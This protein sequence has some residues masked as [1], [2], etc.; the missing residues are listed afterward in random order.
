[1]LLNQLIRINEA[2]T[3]ADSVNFGLMEQRETNQKLC[4]GFVFNYDREKLTESTIGV[5][6][7]LRSSYDS[8]SHANVHLLV[9]QYGKGK[10]HFAVT[11][12][13]YFSK[14]AN[15]PEVEGILQQVENATG[16][17]TNAL[18]E[19]LRLYKNQGRHLVLCLSGDRSGDIKK[20]FLQSLLRV[21]E[22]EGITDS[23]AQHICSE[24]LNYLQGLDSDQRERAETYLEEEGSSDGDVNSITQ[25]L[26]K[27]N[28]AV[29]PTLKKLARHLTGFVPDW[30]IGVDIENVLENLI[31]THCSGE[32]SR[33][34]G[35][36][37]LF[38]ELNFYLQNWAKDPIGSGGTALQNIT[39]IC[40]KHKGKIALLSFTQI[41]PAQGVGI[42]AGARDNHQRLVSRL[43]PNGSTY[44]KVASS[45]ELVIKNL[46]IQDEDSH[47]WKS[48]QTTWN[49]T[50]AAETTNAYEKRILSY[51][52]KGWTRKEFHQILTIGC[53]PLHPLT[54]YL[55]CNLDFTVD[56]T[57]LQFIKKEAKEFIQN[58]PLT[59]DNANQKLNFIYPISLIDTFLANFAED[60]NYG[61]YREA[62]NAVAGSDDPKELIVLKALFLY[63]ASN[64]RLIKDDRE[65]HEEVLATLTGLSVLEVNAT[66]KKLITREV[67]AYKSEV[68]L[69]RFW[70]GIAPAGIEKEIEDRIKEGK[71][72]ISVERVVS[73][74]QNNI[75]QFL[76]SKK[77][78]AQHFVDANKL[79]TE[80][81]QFEYKV[82]TIDSFTRA[83]S[84]DQTLR[85]TEER[86]F[87]AYVLAETQAE[88]Q[89]FRQRV[90][91]LLANSP[92]R[93]RIAVAIPSDETGDLATVLL[94]IQTLKNTG[95]AERRSSSQAYDE[96]L[97]RWESQVRIQA[98]NLLK[99]CTYHCVG[100]EKIPQSERQNSQ[101]FISLLLDNLYP[102]VPPVDGV[103]KLKSTHTTGRKVVSYICRMLLEE[104]L[105]S[106]FPDKTFSFVDS[107]FVRSWGILK[108]KS[109]K[110]LAQEPTNERVKAGWDLISNIADLGE[111][112]EKIID[113]QKVWK[114]LSDPPYGYSEYNFTMLLVGWLSYHRKEVALKGN[115]TILSVSK[116]SAASTSIE[117]KSLREWAG[118]NIL[119]NPVD[120]VK[121][122]IVTGNAKLIRRKK[123]VSPSL[124]Q[125]P[126][127]YSQAQQYLSELQTYLETGDPD[128]SERDRAI[129]SRDLVHKGVT[130]I[131]D[132]FQPI[133]ETES[134]A[135]NAPIESLLLVYPKLLLA[136]PIPILI[137]DLISI[138][139]T[140]Q[141]RGRQAQALQSVSE[142]IERLVDTHCEK[143]ETLP[144][145]EACGVHKSEIQR[146]IA[147]ISQVGSLPP[148]LNDTLQYSLQAVERRLIELK[149]AAKVSDCLSQIQN[150]YKSLGNSP[151]QQDYI[152]TRETIENLAQ[153]APAV[154]QKEDYEKILQELDR[155][156]NG[157][158]QKL[159]IWEGQALGLDSTEQ[160]QK[161]M[162]EVRE[163]R[164]RFTEDE[165]VRKITKLL[166]YLEREQS[167][168]QSTD[169]AVKTIK[170]TLSDANRKL[171]RI[172]DVA[173][174]RVRDAF[175]SYQELMQITLPT[176][177]SSVALEQYQQELE[178]FKVKGRSVL[179]SEGFAKFYN[180][181]LKRLED[182]AR[183]K[184][185]LQELL[186]SIVT[187]ENFADVKVS[188]E[189]AIQNLEIRHAELQEQ[190]QEQK[191][192]SQDE[193]IIQFIRN[194]YKLPKLNT[195]QFLEDGIK[196]IQNFQSRFHTVELFSVEIGQI[197]HTLQDKI[198][199]H[200]KSLEGLR[201][202]LT[203][204]STL[205]DL[206]LV[207]IDLTRLEFIFKDSSEYSNYQ[208]LQQQMQQFRDDMEK[209]QALENRSQQSYSIASCHQMLAAIDHEQITLY[210]LARFQPKLDDLRNNIQYKIQTYTQELDD[211][212]HRLEHLTTSKEA[213]KLHEELLKKSACYDRSESSDRY[214]RINTNIRGLFELFQISEAENIKT[215]EACQSQ[216]EKLTQ[217]K[218]NTN[219]L[220]PL[221]QERFDSIHQ[222]IVQTELRLLQRQQGDAEKWLKMIEIQA[223]EL[224]SL[225]TDAEKN[226]L[227]NSLL[228]KLQQNRDRYIDKLS[229]EH[230][231]SLNA[232]QNQCELE[233]DKNREY[234]IKILFQQ[235]PRSQRV[236][237]YHQLGEYLLDTTEEFDG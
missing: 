143:S 187:R 109:Q 74:C 181:E 36:L 208:F 185:K 66:L 186:E 4:E 3:V 121:K 84:S 12:A 147:Q 146:L 222:A 226:K 25:Q 223:A 57:A 162:G 229:D 234:Q 217:W 133:E 124:P 213:Q 220:D 102:F 93:T 95:V 177:D 154:K 136:P 134:L 224:Q 141:Q 126:I 156:L 106:T 39:N 11:I 88:L 29:I 137:E 200:R 21:L 125:S 189:Q 103:D 69:Y 9:Q 173:A 56:R 41:H 204:T 203:Y 206:D 122:W 24:P 175:L 225:I 192:K 193:Q 38:D 160:V 209:L 70:S 190:Q 10:S 28:P 92:I 183:I 2:G 71:E 116:K 19:R 201:D 205:K 129:Q 161:L 176:I 230:Q 13:N 53:F 52:N 63:H 99:S 180:L 100:I 75:E 1:M 22:A 132:W 166:E 31:T 35:I 165:S 135:D 16:G 119:E 47:E 45:L 228:H 155:C 152:V 67:I 236:N 79:V 81:W 82:Y 212:E 87:V 98:R 76:G 159:E 42:S 207:Q 184:N 179:I 43:A 64:S 33:F 94:K 50:L 164:Y 191:R 107:V 6:E 85:G 105:T 20:Q 61:K 117:I 150:R 90:N 91:D 30:N 86:G 233:I 40:E 26:Q 49:D 148:H 27:N 167:K 188:L 65:P 14:L 32:N 46:L 89:N 17:Q 145:E 139:P 115:A 168:G 18:A 170:A 7:A 221:L 73:F 138:Q 232:I 157:L 120:F 218:E 48:F 108:K 58:Q 59:I 144:T 174:S 142:T 235:L 72:D 96:L 227:A 104:N 149:K 182:Y 216:V 62:Y 51:R 215:L 131:S 158:N 80:D 231:N 113:L 118:T 211:F 55:L 68:K 172:R 153:A 214:E 140:T 178:G 123:V 5:L 77:L 101:R 197:I 198:A 127:D 169:D 34:Q 110:Y 112:S 171:E 114:A 151:T 237:V 83:L 37:I 111:Q 196:D 54:A 130:Q 44:Q 219:D 60:S 202:R 97:K 199:N 78:V 15:S 23:I 8:R 163:W 194:K 195:V 210:H 128:P